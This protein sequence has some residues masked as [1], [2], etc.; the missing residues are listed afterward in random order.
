MLFL[1]SHMSHDEI[2]V[3]SDS[4]TFLF[5]YAKRIPSFL[6][7]LILVFILDLEPS[8]TDLLEFRWVQ[9]SPFS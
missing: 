1:F 2:E 9:I 7:K 6:L 8:Y 5:I 3:Q 4:L